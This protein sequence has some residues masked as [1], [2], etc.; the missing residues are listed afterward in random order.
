[1]AD[2]VT[3]QSSTPA[4]PPS[5]TVIS[6]EEVTTLNGGPVTA[7][8][9][10]R[11][12]IALRTADATAI[13]LPGDSTNGLDVDVTRVQGTVQALGT[14]QGHGTFHVLGTVQSHGT[15]QALGTFQPLAGSVHLAAGSVFAQ[16]VVAHGVAAAGN[17]VLFGGF[18]SSGTQAAVSDGQ[19]VR[20]WFD[21]N[22]RMQ[23]RGTIDSLPNVTI[24]AA[25]PAGNNN[26][27]D[28][29][30]ASMPTVT[31]Q[32]TNLDIR[33]LSS[34]SDSV[35]VVGTVQTHGT[36]QVL[37]TVQAHGT[38]QVIGTVQTHGTSQALGSVQAV[39]TTQTKEVRSTTPAV[40][41]VAATIGNI[42]LLGLTTGRLGAA[43]YVDE[44]ATM[45]LRL[46]SNA[47]TLD[48]TVQVPPGGYYELPFGY[49]GTVA[50]IWKFTGGS[51]RITEI[52]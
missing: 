24:G 47:G 14:I 44:G 43:F 33:D 27:G 18:G 45:Y 1:M 36:S 39:G 4:T 6:T 22:G 12:A 9:V 13:D 25:L 21:L 8:Q 28:V 37:G 52:T 2:N 49:I 10:Q 30:V 46:G 31:V 3:F 50:A 40:M 15:N 32:A 34:V 48:Y 20:P 17:P 51:V 19:L 29:D 35:S 26:I 23:I 38:S 7:Q 41:S 42:T 5:A 16:G 11:T